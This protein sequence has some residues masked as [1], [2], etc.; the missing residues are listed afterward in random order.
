VSQAAASGLAAGAPTARMVHRDGAP[1]Y[2]DFGW[3]EL[4][5]IRTI[6]AG[7]RRSPGAIAPM[8]SGNGPVERVGARGGE[9]CT[10]ERRLV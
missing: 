4:S 1:A 7:A 2:L 6:S 3:A 10:G 5:E 9:S 8:A